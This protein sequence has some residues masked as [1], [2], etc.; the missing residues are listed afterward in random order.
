MPEIQG[1][2]RIESAPP[3]SIG[4][5]LSATD[6]MQETAPMT[7]DASPAR[8]RLLAALLALGTTTAVAAE[9]PDRSL[10]GE[11]AHKVVYQL[12][13]ADEAYID[14]I[15]Y[16]AG[17]LLRKYDDDIRIVITLI[18][19]GVHLVGTNPERPVSKLARQRAESLAMYGVEFH[20]CG[21]TLNTLGWT[22]EDV[23]DYA[24]IVE[25]GADDLMLLQ[26]QG[27]SYISW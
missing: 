26:E 1:I 7:A 10:F 20:V 18:G 8:R 4:L 21:N 25:I 22:A 13:K 5:S 23:L 11:P 12:N 9:A 6:A 15:L 2:A 27:F 24:S 19:P 17:E 14:S 3:L 16:S